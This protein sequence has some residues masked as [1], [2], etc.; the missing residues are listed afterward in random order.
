[1]LSGLRGAGC[2]ESGLQRGVEQA[3][4]GHLPVLQG[5]VGGGLEVKTE[6]ILDEITPTDEEHTQEMKLVERVFR[7]L[8]DY[9]VEPILVGSLAKDTDLSGNKDIDIFIQFR[10][11]VKRDVLERE[12]LRIGKEVF[13]KLGVGYE[14]DYAEHPYVKGFFEGN[15]IEIVPCYK[16]RDIMSAVDRTPLHTRYVKDRLAKK[17]L[18]GDI[19]LL[20][21]FMRGAGVYGAEAKVEGFS[22]YLVEILV[23]H[24]GSFVK[25]LEAAREWSVPEIL[26]PEGL[27]D[28]PEGLGRF[29]TDACL[30]VVDPVDRSRNV[31]AAVSPESLSRFIVRANDY[32]MKP[33]RE[34]FFPP[35]KPMREVEELRDSMLG[36]GSRFAGLVFRH[37][38][39]N[40]N[41]LYAQLRKTTR[42]IVKEF[43][44]AEFKVFRSSFWTN[45]RDTSVIMMEFAVWEL[46]ELV[47]HLGPPIDLD[48]VHQ[49]RF[50]EKYKDE[51]PYV[52][53]GRWVVDT[54]RKHRFVG[55]LLDEVI[56]ERRG[57]GKNFREMGEPEVLFDES[58]L[59]LDCEGWL[60]ELNGY[61]G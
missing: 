5:R 46:P 45:E 54:R 2:G 56:S 8:E 40:V 34:F 14:I 27:W 52:R 12:G 31:A 24:Y 21:Q 49:E 30:I 6:E 38:L 3:R 29:F 43:E 13:A 33:G 51:S 39:L 36:R 42:H 10:K 60:K 57:F 23:L 47:H 44:H 19:R 28:D 59:E 9:E 15:E 35:E 18:K 11:D 4:R 61:L 58:L 22:G 55:E 41:T 7:I 20:K 37:G 32:V 48:A 50:T 26:D 16:G 1:M 17:P 53:D 25:V